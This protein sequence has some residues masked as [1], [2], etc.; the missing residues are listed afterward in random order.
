[1]PEK[2]LPP[3]D[4]MLVPSTAPIPRALRQTPI[5][6]NL[7]P[8][9]VSSPDEHPGIRGIKASKTFHEAA[10]AKLNG[11]N[12]LKAK[13][14][15]TMNAPQIATELE[16]AGRKVKADIQQ[17]FAAAAE[18]IDGEIK[19]ANGFIEAMGSFKE[20]KQASEMRQVLR[21]LKPQ[22][23]TEAIDRALEDE[24]ERLLSAVFDAHPITLGVTKPFLDG[25]RS[26]W[27]AKACPDTLRNLAALT[28]ERERLQES[29]VVALRT[30]DEA[31]R[32]IEEFAP[33]IEA[34]KAA[35]AAL[36]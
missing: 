12:E 20:D 3:K 27:L 30:A 5:P 22:E 35:R 33:Q 25:A 26:R 1:M 28:K 14:L 23:R 10:F 9:Y 17:R 18:T 15:P 32:G 34:A 36:Q 24:D 8:G 2:V 16:A 21:A 13:P 29:V 11:L 7:H 19:E 4:M 6:E 31:S